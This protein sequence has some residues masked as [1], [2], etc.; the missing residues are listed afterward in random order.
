MLQG[1][2][3]VLRIVSAFLSVNNK[4]FFGKTVQEYDNVFFNHKQLMCFL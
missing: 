2:F 1:H 4:R 3:N